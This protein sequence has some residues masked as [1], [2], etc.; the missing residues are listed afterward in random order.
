[1]TNFYQKKCVSFLYTH[2]FTHSTLT[3]QQTCFPNKDKVLPGAQFVY[4]SGIKSLT[5]ETNKLNGTHS[6]FSTPALP[7]LQDGF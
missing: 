1:M 5:R 4:Y 3:Y 7:A 2:L 6:H